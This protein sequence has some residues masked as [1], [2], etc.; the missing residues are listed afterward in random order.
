LLPSPSGLRIKAVRCTIIDIFTAVKT[1]N[2]NH[3]HLKKSLLFNSKV[4]LWR[5]IALERIQC[6][7]RNTTFRKLDLFPSSG[8]PGRKQIQFPKRR[9]FFKKH[10][11]MDRV[12]KHDSFKSVLLLYLAT[13]DMELSF[14]IVSI[15]FT[16]K[17]IVNKTCKYTF[18]AY[19]CHHQCRQI[20]RL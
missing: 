15:K 7:S 11:T 5:C 14:C 9:C 16:M 4:F 20:T 12:N 17:F 19:E 3:Q 8:L 10:W 13:S 2:L 6:F 1:S 18:I